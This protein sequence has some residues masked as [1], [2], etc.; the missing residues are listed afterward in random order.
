MPK[1]WITVSTKMERSDYEKLQALAK[2]EGKTESAMIKLAIELLFDAHP[3]MNILKGLVTS[4]LMESFTPNLME[5]FKPIITKAI[6]TAQTEYN[7]I[8]EDN[9]EIESVVNI[10]KNFSEN[11][12]KVNNSSDFEPKPAGRPKK[13]DSKTKGIYGLRSVKE[14]VKVEKDIVKK[15]KKTSKTKKT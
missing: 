13:R 6:E 12:T 4:G 5:A 2:E 14:V 3:K 8:K 11:I 10:F 9:P 15:N 1:D 7:K